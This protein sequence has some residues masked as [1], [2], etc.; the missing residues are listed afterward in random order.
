[1]K[2][3]HTPTP[4][5]LSFKSRYLPATYLVIGFGLITL[6]IFLFGAD[7]AADLGFI[8]KKISDVAQSSGEPDEKKPSIDINF[9]VPA[10]NPRRILIPEIGAEGFVQQV[11]VDESG[12]IDVPD[13]IHMAGWYNQSSNVGDLGLSIIAGHVRGY[14][15]SG[16]FEQLTHLD[17]GQQFE[18][19]MGDRSIKKFEIFKAKTVP[20][21]DSLL[22]MY[23]RT[24]KSQL[25]LITCA[26]DF[27]STSETYADRHIVYAKPV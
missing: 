23:E 27:N 24:E 16:I 21:E 6:C 9:E 17:P 1:M 11:G 19:E 18:V 2:S 25:N 14:T 15:T 3:P 7:L 5:K 22:A 20:V 26:G 10:Q 12:A 8:E 13:N 4:R